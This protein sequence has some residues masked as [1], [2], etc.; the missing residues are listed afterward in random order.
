MKKIPIIDVNPFENFYLDLDGVF[1]DFDGRFFSIAGKWPHQVEK[2]TLWK[3]VNSH[4]DYFYSLELTEGALQLWEYARQFN[5]IFLT[6]LP[7]KQNGREQKIRWVADK[8]G[9]EWTVIVLPKREKQNY[10]GANRVLIDDTMVNIEQWVQRGGHGVHHKGD[11]WETI[12]QVELLRTTL[13]KNSV[14]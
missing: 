13:L 3:I 4:D 12:D 5:P 2:K 7:G 9:P 11:V 6:G 8:F 1:A 14:E 10:A